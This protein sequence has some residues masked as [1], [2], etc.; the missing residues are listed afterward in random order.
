MTLDASPIGSNPECLLPPSGSYSDSQ[1]VALLTSLPFSETLNLI[2]HVSHN[3]GAD[4]L[5]F[6]IALKNGHNT[7]DDGMHDMLPFLKTTA[8]DTTA[9]SLGDGRGNDRADLFS[10]YTATVCCARW[11]PGRTPRLPDALPLLGEKGFRRSTR[12]PPIV[13]SGQGGRQERNDLVGD[14]LNQRIMTLG[15][16][17]WPATLQ[18]SRAARWFFRSTSRTSLQI[19][20][21]TS[22]SPLRTR[23]RWSR[24]STNAIEEI[25]LEDI[26]Q[27][28]IRA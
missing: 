17:V 16:A 26:Q 22:S 15:C 9:V 10:P 27:V 28:E 7:F 3:Q 12:C 1:R 18:R 14:L 8:V 6:L 19:S 2:F 24:P 11:R 13:Q 21:R 4:T 23:G 5:V 20:S 25:G